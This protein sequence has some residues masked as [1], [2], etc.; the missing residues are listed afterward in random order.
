[1]VEYKRRPDGSF[2]LMEINPRLWGSLALA[3]DTGVNFPLGLLSLA[4]GRPLRPQ[5]QFRR[6][7]YTRSFKDDLSWL[8]ANLAADPADPTLLTRPR[9]RSFLELLRPLIGRESW[10]HFDF[11]DLRV[12]WTLLR[13]VWARYVGGLGVLLRRKV[14]ARKAV[15][16]HRKLL[17][18]TTLPR[19]GSGNILFLCYGNICRSPF[20]EHVARTKLSG[21]RIVSAGFHHTVGRKT[22]LDFL[23][24]AT[25]FGID[26]AGRR[27]A[28]ITWRHVAE[29]DL[30]LVMD[31]AN[32]EQLSREFPEA[33]GRTT[34]LGLFAA[35]PFVSIDDPY[36][37]AEAQVRRILEKICIS[38][39]GLASTLTATAA[40]AG[41]PAAAHRA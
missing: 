3:I 24:I 40:E 5:P 10:D 32:Y 8:R 26:L 29:A 6:T 25:S 41:M 20:A 15:E 13:E 14:L 36:H 23:N 4:Q 30:I 1:M 39:E 9:V 34:L 18:N 31:L 21:Y 17:A 7:Y 16:Q 35:E 11:R 33:R 38:V 19:H 28:R 37:A 12:T 2:C 27:S 22:P